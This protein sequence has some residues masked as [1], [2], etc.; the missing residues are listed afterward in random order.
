MRPFLRKPCKLTSK[1]YQAA[2]HMLNG[3]LE[4][5]PRA[6]KNSKLSNKELLKILEFRIPATWSKEMT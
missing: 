3:Y 1:E 5:F 6:D 2:L 4:K